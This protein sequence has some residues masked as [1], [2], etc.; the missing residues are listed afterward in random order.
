MNKARDGQAASGFANDEKV[1]HRYEELVDE[2]DEVQALS[3]LAQALREGALPELV[4]TFKEALATFGDTEVAYQI[5]QKSA[6]SNTQ[7]GLLYSSLG[8]LAIALDRA[9]EAIDHF[10]KAQALGESGADLYQLWAG[11][12]VSLGE[13]EHGEELFSTALEIAP[14]RVSEVYSAW[15]KALCDA[16]FT[17]LA[18]EKLIVAIAADE[19]A[20]Y[21][22]AYLGVVHLQEANE[23]LAQPAFQRALE[24]LPGGYETYGAWIVLELSNVMERRDGK[25][26]A[27]GMICEQMQKG[28]RSMAL[29]ER[30]RRLQNLTLGPG[31]K[32]FILVVAGEDAKG[33]YYEECEV[34][35]DSE[36][37]ALDFVKAI[38]PGNEAANLVIADAKVAGKAQGTLA[39]I[40]DLSDKTRV[41]AWNEPRPDEEDDDS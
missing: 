25:E 26:A 41:P 4:A 19:R 16:G 11:A 12:C 3:C 36:S 21:P 6:E 15:G 38:H 10:E 40:V 39:G 24:L 35:A 17:K 1:L 8:E 29:L 23:D 18:K 30:L 33:D 7:S 13:V 2:D 28:R 9:P 5:C 14:D 27:M 37:A 20:F 31:S 34:D 22:H 32:H